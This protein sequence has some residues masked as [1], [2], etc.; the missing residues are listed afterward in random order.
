MMMQLNKY[1]AH[2]G[3]ASR[4][5]AVEPIKAGK[6]RVNG[7]IVYDPAF[8]VNP[9][10]DEVSL[11]GKPVRLSKQYRYVLLNKPKGTLTTMDDDRGRQTV[12]DLIPKGMRVVPVGRWIMTPKARC[13]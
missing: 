3:I 8:R 10:E 4:R 1:L 7:R 12:V 13:C 2:A 9:E 6:V 5:A 11:K